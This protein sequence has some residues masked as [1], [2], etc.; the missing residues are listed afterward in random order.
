MNIRKWFRLKKTPKTP[1]LSVVPRERSANHQLFPAIDQDQREIR[2]LSFLPCITQLNLELE[3]FGLE[4][5]PDF[6]ALSYTW[7]TVDAD[8]LITLNG[9]THRVRQNLLSAL[10]ALEVQIVAKGAPVGKPKPAWMIS[11]KDIQS[12]IDEYFPKK[13]KTSRRYFWIDA[14]CIDQDNTP[15]RSHQ[16]Q[17]MGEIYSQAEGAL[18]WLG[19]ECGP[20]L[21]ALRD[22]KVHTWN[23][24]IL[25]E[26]FEAD[27]WNRVWTVQ[28][29]ELAKDIVF[30]AGTSF[31]S[32]DAAQKLMKK[33]KIF[34]DEHLLIDRGISVKS[35]R[36]LMSGAPTSAYHILKRLDGRGQLNKF[37][38]EVILFNFNDKQCADPRDTVYALLH[39]GRKEESKLS[40]FKADYSLTPAELCDRL[41]LY[42]VEPWRLS[43]ALR[44]AAQ[45]ESFNK[46]G[47]VTTYS[48][49]TE[50]ES[51]SPSRP[52][53]VLSNRRKSTSG[54]IKSV[55]VQGRNDSEIGNQD[56]ESTSRP[57]RTH[58]N[59]RASKMS[60][61]R[62]ASGSISSIRDRYESK[63]TTTVPDDPSPPQK[64]PGLV[65]GG[66][67]EMQTVPGRGG[68]TFQY[69]GP[70]ISL[71]TVYQPT[72]QGT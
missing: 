54:S 48:M 1:S 46:S 2:L 32:L 72:D 29:F 18:V 59:R 62:R 60:L 10:K 17:L 40:S 14:L 8:E 19:D 13:D 55:L 5:C 6:V 38:P 47:H 15:E 41:E 58:L 63:S 12:R 53:S 9:H 70:D 20:A 36:R 45:K 7:G 21:Q 39:L 37:S 26:F 52:S 35:G 61:Y 44:S 51:A 28:E 42:G 11:P 68:W 57:P 27:Y 24:E 56:R 30:A 22:E 69:E 3:V 23:I 33:A 49:Y 4:T 31:L 67:T 71:P 43:A 25:D 64:S 65:V 16:V 66:T 50:P 34:H